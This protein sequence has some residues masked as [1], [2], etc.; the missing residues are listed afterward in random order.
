MK[1]VKRKC[2]RCG[3]AGLHEK[4]RPAT[5]TVAG[6]SFKASIQALV[7]DSCGAVY[8][9]GPAL[10][11]FDLAVANK[12][13]R[14]GVSDGEAIKFMRKAVGLPAVTPTHSSDSGLCAIPLGWGRWFRSDA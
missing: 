12:L 1:S 4:K 9:N 5:R 8:F 11:N 7:C 2:S 14:A 13:A 6:H 10:G 3:N